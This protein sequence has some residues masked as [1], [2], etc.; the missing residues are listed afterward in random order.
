M[1]HAHPLAGWQPSCC[2]PTPS[3]PWHA[4]LC[5]CL[6][7][8]GGPCK[9]PQ[10]CSTLHPNGGSPA[11]SVGLAYCKFGVRGPG[12]CP[13]HFAPMQPPTPKCPTRL[14]WD[15][16]SLLPWGGG[17]GVTCGTYPGPPTSTHP[18]GFVGGYAC[19]AK[20][21]CCI[22]CCDHQGIANGT[23]R[24]ANQAQGGSL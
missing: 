24:D 15:G 5:P 10:A 12:V 18:R 22:P 3:A 11:T 8:A 4:V 23:Q 13:S 9:V 7:C 6:P 17:M 2:D 16:E 14:S 20:V 1:Q 19:P 21:F